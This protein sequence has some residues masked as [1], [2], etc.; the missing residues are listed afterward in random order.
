[1]SS[2]NDYVTFFENIKAIIELERYSMVHDAVVAAVDEEGDFERLLRLMK[3]CYDS[4]PDRGI[5]R[6]VLMAVK[7]IR[8]LDRQVYE[9]YM[10]LAGGMT[11]T[12]T[13]THG[14]E[15]PQVEYNMGERWMRRLGLLIEWQ[16]SSG[17]PGPD[18]TG[19]QCAG[20]ATWFRIN[21]GPWWLPKEKGALK[22]LD[23]V[24]QSEDEQE[25]RYNIEGKQQFSDK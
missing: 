25:I 23:R 15:P 13:M 4:C 3:A 20:M 10:A 11:M 6:T 22:T 7:P 9:I 16:H 21:G 5:S 1:M 14:Q 8:Y 17:I 2:S 18:V 24:L 19:G 12:M